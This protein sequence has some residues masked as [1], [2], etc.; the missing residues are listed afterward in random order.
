MK[1]TTRCTLSMAAVFLALFGCKTS[2][3]E[4]PPDVRHWGLDLSMATPR[5][6]HL[7][8][9][10]TDLD[11]Q[12]SI[13][14]LEKD[15]AERQK[16]LADLE[17]IDLSQESPGRAYNVKKKIAQAQLRESS[18]YR[19][20]AANRL[21]DNTKQ[22]RLVNPELL[23]EIKKDKDLEA[24]TFK[25]LEIARELATKF[26]F[27]PDENQYM[28]IRVMARQQNQSLPLYYEQFKKA[29][30]VS[31]YAARVDALLAASAFDK[32]DLGKTDSMLKALMENKT[33]EVRPYIA[34]QV[35]WLNIVRA[36][37]EKD[38]KKRGEFLTKAQVGLRLCIKLMD[39][40]KGKK[41]SF[42]LKNEAAHDLAWV[43]AEQELAPADAQKLLK[44]NQAEAFYRDYQKY[45]VME[46]IRANRIPAA[47]AQIKELQFEQEKS[48]D[49]PI[50]SFMLAEAAL[51]KND[52][53]AV[54]QRYQDI[55]G[56]FKAEVPWYEKW[57]DDKK[58]LDL[59]DQQLG[60]HL[61]TTA[62][63]MKAKGEQVE[64]A[65]AAPE[66]AKKAAPDTKDAKAPAPA[67]KPMTRED[68]F[69]RS[70]EF[71]KLY[72]EWYPHGEALDDLR[73]QTALLEYHGGNLEKAIEQLSAIAKDDKSKH[74]KA[75]A[76][77]VMIV[78]SEWDDKQPLPKLPE[79]GKAKKPIPLTKSKTLLIEK[80][81]GYLKE[82]PEAENAVNLT[83]TIASTY[84]AFGHYDKSLPLFESVLQKAPKSELG[85]ASLN[86]YLSYLVEAKHW[87]ELLEKCK[88]YLSNKE[89]AGAGHR[90]LLRETLEYAKSMTPN[91]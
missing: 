53:A 16:E 31:P 58:L 22:W 13:G 46:A 88:E 44:D 66:P 50:Y 65:Q 83:Y 5:I 77:D 48:R 57:K 54:Q 72:A 82:D 39:D 60:N 36:L 15:H 51:A 70:R 11:L 24:G 27:E 76:Y 42:D 49:Y 3:D 85:E 64:V 26:T 87:P 20:M 69:A 86:L 45:A 38:A 79:N 18:Y 41:P 62:M 84:H 67:A 4:M 29:F 71:M 78:A 89:I 8:D 2:S 90:K 91:T 23:L 37:D 19:A 14:D 10:L 35:A 12:E 73:Y 80:I 75:A 52:F 32:R 47:E 59:V 34:F 30:S 9:F 28:L 63:L 43:A 55:R 81:E 40:W 74:K 61:V 6:E 1:M 68:Y 25:I 17:A 21:Y 56:L 33:S 7:E